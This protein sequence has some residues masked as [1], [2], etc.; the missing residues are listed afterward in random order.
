MKILVVVGAK[1]NGKT[2]KLVKQSD[3]R[4]T[5]RFTADCASAVIQEFA[6]TMES[7]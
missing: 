3:L 2:D 1:K 5:I 7:I 4:K 6:E